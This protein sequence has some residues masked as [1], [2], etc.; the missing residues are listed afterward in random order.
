MTGIACTHSVCSQSYVDTGDPRCIAGQQD[1]TPFHLDSTIVGIALVIRAALPDITLRNA[2]V[3]A[4]PTTV[5]GRSFRYGPGGF[6]GFGYD[7][8]TLETALAWYYTL[9]ASEQRNHVRGVQLGVCARLESAT[10]EV[11]ECY[12]AIVRKRN[13]LLIGFERYAR[14]AKR[15][16]RACPLWPGTWNMPRHG[17]E[18]NTIRMWLMSEGLAEVCAALAPTSRGPAYNYMTTSITTKVQS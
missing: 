14:R 8:W 12:G 9:W 6:F 15:A 13:A 5:Q 18:E 4:D 7:R 1:W 16:R 2:L 10:P 17:S 3:Y 11:R